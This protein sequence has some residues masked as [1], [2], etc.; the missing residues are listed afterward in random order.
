MIFSDNTKTVV[1]IEMPKSSVH[2][3]ITFAIGEASVGT[4]WF[5]ESECVCIIITDVLADSS[6]KMLTLFYYLLR[7]VPRGSLTVSKFILGKRSLVSTR[8][9][10]QSGSSSLLSAYS[11]SPC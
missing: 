10:S 6:G 7:Y 4:T 2:T 8:L 9:N 3:S 11:L 1:Y 5:A